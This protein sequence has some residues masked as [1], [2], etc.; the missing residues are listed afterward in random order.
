M[1]IPTNLSR[2]IHTTPNPPHRG[3]RGSRVPCMIVGFQGGSTPNPRNHPHRGGGGGSCRPVPYMR[4]GVDKTRSWCWLVVVA[5]STIRCDH[6]C[7]NHKAI[8]TEDRHI[9]WATSWACPCTLH[10]E[11]SSKRPA[12]PI[13]LATP[14]TSYGHGSIHQQ[15]WG[16]TQLFASTGRVVPSALQ[17]RQWKQPLCNCV[18]YHLVI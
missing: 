6:S 8:W 2:Y 1:P 15:K 18:K 14:V 5:T 4:W 12:C 7:A 17:S 3:G 11:S 9:T 13:S 16:M 10:V